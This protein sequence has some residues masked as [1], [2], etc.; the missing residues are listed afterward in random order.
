MPLAFAIEATA[1][2]VTLTYTGDPSFDEWASTMDEVLQDPAFRP[3]YGLLL[4]RTQL[5]RAPDAEYIQRVVQY[6][7]T[8][9][10]QLGG[11]RVANLVSSDVA[12]GMARMAQ[13]L[14]DRS[15]GTGQ[16]FRDRAEAL[17]WLQAGQSFRAP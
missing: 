14:L 6:M 5:T 1:G 4:D 2:I 17:K 8:H 12:Y 13:T 7:R 3:G 11:G 10:P 16:V 9:A 15:S